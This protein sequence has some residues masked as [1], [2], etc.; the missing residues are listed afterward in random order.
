MLLAEEPPPPPVDRSIDR[1]RFCRIG[2]S[3]FESIRE[4]GGIRSDERLPDE[5]SEGDSHGV[6]SEWM[7]PFVYGDGRSRG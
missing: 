7:D 6:S 3:T 2:P 4:T 5:S 1:T